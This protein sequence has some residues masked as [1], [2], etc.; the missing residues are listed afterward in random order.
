MAKKKK[1][2]NDV[3]ALKKHDRIGAAKH[4]ITTFQGPD[5]IEAYRKKFHVD[6]TTAVYDLRE[7]KYPFNGADF[8]ILEAEQKRVA[9]KQARK[10]GV[11][12]FDDDEIV[13][14]PDSEFAYIAGYT[15]GG[16]PYGTTYA[17][18]ETNRILDLRRELPRIPVPFSELKESEKNWAI[19][20]LNQD[21]DETM[22]LSI[23]LPSEQMKEETLSELCAMLTSS[24][25][26]WCDLHY[27]SV[28]FQESTPLKKVVIDELLSDIYDETVEEIYQEMLE[29]GFDEL[30]TYE[31]AMM[32][33]E[34]RFDLTETERLKLRG[35]RQKDMNAL[36]GIMSKPEVMYAWEA[37]FTKKET[38]NWISTQISRYRKNGYGYFAVILKSTKKLIGQA[39]L[40]RTEANVNGEQIT[41]IGYIFDNE[42]WGNGYALEA[43]RA[44]V[45]LAFHKFG[46]EK[47]CATIRPENT[48]SAKVAEKLGMKKVG[49][50]VKV[51]NN[52]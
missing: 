8:E 25:D 42:Y 32:R 38:R 21:L 29:D 23:Y 43:A 47:I 7:V 33:A 27:K 36:F 40:L 50:Y 17:E 26:Q 5:V 48:A 6:V 44:C 39:G 30:P 22:R 20:I 35:L 45:D 18:L 28:E 12:T 14:Y 37:G 19:D 49:V 2:S 10:V 11:V 34:G 13:G 31:E 41:E 24:L 15:S 3:K 9:D 4:W 52:K 46:L 51:H 1:K 16:A